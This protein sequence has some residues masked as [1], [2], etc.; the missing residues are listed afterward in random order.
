MYGGISM[1]ANNDPVS[2]MKDSSK[3]T[4]IN[5][6]VYRYGYGY[7]LNA[8]TMYLAMVVL[9]LHIAIVPI[10]VCY[11]FVKG[12]HSQAWGSLGDL[13]ALA[14]NSTPNEKLRASSAGITDE[15][16]WTEEVRV[17]LNKD[18]GRFELRFGPAD[19]N[20]NLEV[21]PINATIFR[22]S[23]STRV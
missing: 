8:I 19:H 10:H 21:T 15:E 2:S 9:L 4:M 18:D 5:P 3:A 7:G 11:V 14:V 22:R 12:W 6:P 20:A 23:T 13:L 16:V 1:L 17:Q